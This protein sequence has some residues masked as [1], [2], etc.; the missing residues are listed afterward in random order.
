M[1]VFALVTIRENA[2][3][4]DKVNWTEHQA[5]ILTPDLKD[6]P[7]DEAYRK[8]QMALF[9]LEDRHSR[10]QKP[11]VALKHS[12]AATVMS[13]IKS[14]QL[15]DIGYLSVPGLRG[16][17]VDATR[18]FSSQLC[19]RI[20]ELAP[21]SSKGWIVDLRENTGGNMWP[22]LGGLHPLLGSG[23]VGELRDREGVA[24]TPWRSRA[25]KRCDVDLS[26]ARVAVLVGPNTASSGE[27]V[28]VAFRARP[29][30]RFFGHRT[31]GLATS[32]QGYPLPDGGVLLLTTA[33]FLDRAG[34]SYPQGIS[35][36]S[37]LSGSEDAVEAAAAWLR[38]TP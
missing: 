38:S 5:S 26:N 6:L 32:N 21:T 27:A 20:E 22:M 36:D 3:N 2:L 9:L 10:L 4:A 15:Q 19:D 14:R 23:K 12:Q 13:A 34:E 31:K 29:G 28:A 33:E 24:N 18:Q 25:P 11:R 30:T 17:G 35:P 16:R 1:M 8:I 37:P 7:S